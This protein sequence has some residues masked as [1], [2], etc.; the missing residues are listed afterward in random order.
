LSGQRLKFN[1][2]EW[3]VILFFVQWSPLP[4]LVSIDRDSCE[5]VVKVRQAFYFLLFIFIKFF[6]F[7]F[8][9]PGFLSEC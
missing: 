3:A 2:G 1:H 5:S 6:R 9:F 8:A 4:L 7:C